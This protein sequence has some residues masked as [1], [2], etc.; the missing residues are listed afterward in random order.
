M[1]FEIFKGKYTAGELNPGYFWR[2]RAR[3]GR[4]ISDG[5]EG[6]QRK[7]QAKKAIKRLQEGIAFATIKDLT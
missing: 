7:S 3:N 6:Y 4:I 1:K 2:L 5:S